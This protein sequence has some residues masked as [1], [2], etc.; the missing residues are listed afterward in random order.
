M[1]LASAIGVPFAVLVSSGALAGWALDNKL[2][3]T[4]WFM[5]GGLVLG[6]VAAFVNLVRVVAWQQRRDSEAEQPDDGEHDNPG[7]P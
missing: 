1:A 6:A 7:R 3:S 4:P 2:Q 5:L